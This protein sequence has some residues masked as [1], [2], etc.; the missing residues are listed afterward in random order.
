MIA[1]EGP[2][3]TRDAVVPR[4]SS[5]RAKLI[6]L[7]LTREAPATAGE[8]AA[9]LGLRKLAVYGVLQ[10]LRERE[11]VEKREGGYAVR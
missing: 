4:S 5:P 8:I 11:L 1:D 6:Y 7:Y 3:T 9:G 10:S 2:S